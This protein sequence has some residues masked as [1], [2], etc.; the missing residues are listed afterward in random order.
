ML[1]A[2]G[3]L[4]ALNGEAFV[5]AVGQLL[6]D[7]AL[8]EFDDA[9]RLFTVVDGSHA[10]LDELALKRGLLLLNHFVWQF[11]LFVVSPIN[12]IPDETID[13]LARASHFLVDLF[14]GVLAINTLTVASMDQTCKLMQLVAL[15]ETNVHQIDERAAIL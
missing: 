4:K 14:H 9:N 3:D 12:F 6:D 2:L 8:V 5:A 7:A 15:Q 11:Y 10:L 1:E 13:V